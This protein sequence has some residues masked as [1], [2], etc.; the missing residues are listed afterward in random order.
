MGTKRI[1]LGNQLV[2]KYYLMKIIRY[3]EAPLQEFLVGVV[4]I[5]GNYTLWN[6]VD[7]L[8]NAYTK[9]TKLIPINVE[10][11]YWLSFNY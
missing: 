4:P 9:P 11:F 3:K 1:I 10:T 2:S 5:K 8:F 6:M 7:L